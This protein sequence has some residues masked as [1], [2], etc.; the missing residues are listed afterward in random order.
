MSMLNRHRGMSARELSEL[1]LCDKEYGNPIGTLRTHLYRLRN[2]FELLSESDLIVT[3]SNGYRINPDLKI[4]TDYDQFEKLCGSIKPVM[5]DQKQIE[6]LKEAVKIYTG[7][8]FPNGDG[9][10]WHIS[11]SMKYHSLYIK[12]FEQLMGLLNKT[13]DYKALHDYSMRAINVDPNSP[14]IIYWLVV[15]LRKSGAIEMAQKHLE[16]AKARLLEEEYQELEYR[17]KIAV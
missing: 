7:K 17:L 1:V 3:K 10:L 9:D 8:L 11:C 14:A 5:A 15:A 16:S 4:V 2:M 13:E 6:I 12:A